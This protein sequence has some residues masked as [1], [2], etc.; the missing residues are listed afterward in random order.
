M[1]DPWSWMLPIVSLRSSHP[2]VVNMNDTWEPM[3]L[4][5]SET[6]DVSRMG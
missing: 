1:T 6:G 2:W 3:G 5:K 4:L